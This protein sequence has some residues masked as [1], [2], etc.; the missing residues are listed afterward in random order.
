VV[1][2]RGENAAK[3]RADAL[4]RLGQELGDR[5]ARDLP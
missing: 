3:A 1:N 2:G 5:L 4:L